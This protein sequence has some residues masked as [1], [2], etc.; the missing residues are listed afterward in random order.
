M[1]ALMLME[2][3]NQSVV[4]STSMYVLCKYYVPTRVRLY[5]IVCM[6]SGPREFAHLGTTETSRRNFTSRFAQRLCYSFTCLAMRIV[7]DNTIHSH[8]ISSSAVGRIAECKKTAM[9]ELTLLKL[10][11]AHG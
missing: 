11:H 7:R 10:D 3:K 1:V 8:R 9:T 4:C 2:S 5:Y 6:V